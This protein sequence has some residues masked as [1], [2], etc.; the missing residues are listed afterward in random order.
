LRRETWCAV[1][2]KQ[3]RPTTSNFFHASPQIVERGAGMT[4]EVLT[5]GRQSDRSGAPLKK[6]CAHRAFKLADRVADGARRQMEFVCSITKRAG[7]RGRFEGTDRR[8][9]NT[10]EQHSI[11][12]PDS[13]IQDNCAFVGAQATA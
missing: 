4:H 10:G 6:R 13:S 3:L 9:R 5:G 8:D 7:A 12:E 2:P 11:S 1:H